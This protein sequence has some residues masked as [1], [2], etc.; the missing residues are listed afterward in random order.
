[1][2]GQQVQVQAAII[3]TNSGRPLPITTTNGLRVTFQ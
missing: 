1:M 2:R 3:D